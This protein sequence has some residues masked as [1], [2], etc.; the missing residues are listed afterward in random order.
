MN[1]SRPERRRAPRFRLA[2]RPPCGLHAALDAVL[3]DVST[4]G[5]LVEHTHPVQPNMIYTLALPAGQQTVLIVARV[6]RT[7]LSH[8][9]D[10]SQG[11]RSLV[12]HTGLEF[13]EISEEA[14]TAL[15]ALIPP[16]PLRAS[17]PTGRIALV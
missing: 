9:T 11:P 3:L 12:F 14:R 8:I 2:G 6:V 17:F 13:V 7:L 4:C 1:A 16:P 10:R 15:E 5:V